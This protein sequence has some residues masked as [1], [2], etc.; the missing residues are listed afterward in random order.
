MAKQLKI[1]YFVDR[2]LI[3]GIQKLVL[4]IAKN[5]DKEKFQLDFL[6]LDDGKEY[7]LENTLKNLK[8]KVYKLKSVWIKNPFDYINYYIK[9]KNFFKETGKYYDI[10]HLHS[11]SKNFLFLYLA[12]KSNIKVRIAH[13]HT[14]G[15]KTS[16]YLKETIGNIM[17]YFLVKNATNFMACSKDA[18]KWLFGEKKV[19][20][21]I[22]LKNSID[23][24]KYKY[25]EKIRKK[26]REEFNLLEDDIVCG[27]VGRV[28]EQKNHKF[29]L[30]IFKEVLKI[31]NKYKLLIV[32][33][34]NNS[35]KEELDKYVKKFDMSENIIFTGFRNNS[36]E[37]LNA[38]DLFLFPSKVEGL[39]IALIEAQSNGLK[40]IVS[41]NIPEEAKVS[42]NVITINLNNEKD[43]VEKI[44]N[45][46]KTRNDCKKQIED[47][48]YD[49]KEM[50]R[51]LGSYYSDLL[52]L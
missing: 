27:N 21:I 38:M 52:K 45:I 9:M 41:E 16:N 5:I 12:K 32:G 28:V 35:L 49:I 30:E 47:A 31:N 4:E 1:L 51:K 25:N 11:S 29:L 7:E 26:I 19:K 18:G 43:W 20:D 40:C 39:G 34:Y 2:M 10:V 48:G 24:S 42:D 36:N 37:Y 44:I 15:F 3:G 23:I 8:C 33:D 17:K 14:T 22:V 46:D 50:V 13:S 6:L